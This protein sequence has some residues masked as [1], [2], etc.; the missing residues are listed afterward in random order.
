VGGRLCGARKKKKEGKERKAGYLPSEDGL[1]PVQIK[2]YRKEKKPR[3]KKI[4]RYQ[5]A[6]P[7]RGKAREGE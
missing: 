4:F 3:R 1:S 5:E 7:S 2:T 6:R